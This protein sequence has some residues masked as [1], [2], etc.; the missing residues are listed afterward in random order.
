[1]LFKN[2]CKHEFKL[3]VLVLFVDSLNPKH[4]ESRFDAAKLES[5]ACLLIINKLRRRNHLSFI[6]FENSEVHGFAN[7]LFGV[8]GNE[9]TGE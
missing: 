4:D 7:Y 2:I 1:M 6:F 5:N 8:C 9:W 3:I